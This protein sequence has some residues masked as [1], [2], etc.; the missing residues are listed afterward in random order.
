VVAHHEEQIV[1]RPCIKISSR[2]SDKFPWHRLINGSGSSTLPVSSTVPALPSTVTIFPVRRSCVALPVPQQRPGGQIPG[3]AGAVCH[4]IE[5][6]AKQR[7][8]LAQRGRTAL[9]PCCQLSPWPW[10]RS[11]REGE[12]GHLHSPE[13]PVPVRCCAAAFSLFADPCTAWG[14]R[15]RDA[16]A[17]VTAGGRARALK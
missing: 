4:P 14:N 1:F 13:S 6:V 7:R 2:S 8:K 10:R 5:R 15:R 12:T 11:G 17:S 16:R 9:P 3:A